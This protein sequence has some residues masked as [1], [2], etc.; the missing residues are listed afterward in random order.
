MKA[1]VHEKI[2]QLVPENEGEKR[3]LERFWNAQ[4]IFMQSFGVHGTG[5]EA[6]FRLTL[7]RHPTRVGKRPLH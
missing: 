3:L 1:K 6:E 7:I 5:I 2:I 4:D